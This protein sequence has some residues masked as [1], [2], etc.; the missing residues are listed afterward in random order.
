MIYT[1][2]D[3]TL[4]FTKLK[5]QENSFLKILYHRKNM[6]VIEIVILIVNV[7]FSHFRIQDR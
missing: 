2:E 7:I 1:A 4:P 6:S 5:T 3:K